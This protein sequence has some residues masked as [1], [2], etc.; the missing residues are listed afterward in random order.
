MIAGVTGDLFLGLMSGTSMDAVDAVLADFGA[1]IPQ[2][3][4]GISRPIP[5]DLRQAIG[6]LCQPGNDCIDHLG[7]VDCELGELF[8]AAALAVLAA[9]HTSASQV[10]AIGSHGQTIRHRPPGTVE[11]PFTLQIGDPNRI[12]SIT[13]ITTVADFRRRDLAEGGQGAPLVPAFHRDLFRHPH[14]HRA[15]VNIGG[16]AN[17]TWLP[18]SGDVLGFDTGPGNVLMDAWHQKHRG[19]P[20]DDQ[21]RWASGARA[22]QEL[23]TQLKSHPYFARWYPKTTGREDFHLHF[24]EGAL[25]RC[26]HEVEPQQIQATLL[27]LTA[28]TIAAGIISLP[29]PP[30]QIYLCG[31][32]AYNTALVAALADLLRP[33]QVATTS[34]LGV[35]PRWVEATA[36]AWLARQTLLGLSGNLPTVT[37]AR[38]QTVL[39]GI[40][41]A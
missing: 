13:G 22:D 16:I 14:Q 2:L 9:T 10:R 30:E 7:R 1:P 4:G 18:A 23:L 38:K 32:G 19:A 24:L 39:G 37:G 17:V 6:E 11:Y 28:E 15:V 40:Y 27:A 34:A 33:A 21:G 31:G 12:A 3:L 41:P 26:S 35:D 5:G 36:F 25:K 20:F 29:Q 8:A